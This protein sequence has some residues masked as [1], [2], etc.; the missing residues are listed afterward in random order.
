MTI[1][2]LC[3]FIITAFAMLRYAYELSMSA[4]V[5]GTLKIP[6]WPMIGCIGLGFGGIIFALLTDLLILLSGK[7]IEQQWEQEQSL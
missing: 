4:V 7:E 1:L 3:F 5:S 2:A 6:Y